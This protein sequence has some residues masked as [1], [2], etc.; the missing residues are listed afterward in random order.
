VSEVENWLGGGGGDGAAGEEDEARGG[1][2]LVGEPSLQERESEMGGE[3]C[4]ALEVEVNGGGVP[5]DELRSWR[6]AVEVV[7]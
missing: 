2:A 7:A 3:V 1:E 5:E 4:G 6:P